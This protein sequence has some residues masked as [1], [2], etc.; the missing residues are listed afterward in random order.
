M[1]TP[2]EILIPPSDASPIDPG[3]IDA[4]ITDI[5]AELC[6]V[7]AALIEL[8][9]TQLAEIQADVAA[10]DKAVLDVADDE[11]ADVTWETLNALTTLENAA[12]ANLYETWIAAHY[13][14]ADVPIDAFPVPQSH[15][16]NPPLP[17]NPRPKGRRKKGIPEVPAP[18]PGN[19]AASPPVRRP[20]ALDTQAQ[21]DDDDDL[22]PPG[23]GSPGSSPP[24]G[25]FPPLPN[26]PTGSGASVGASS[27]V[28]PGSSLPG[29]ILLPG[30]GSS[31]AALPLSPASSG[32]AAGAPP[33]A[34]PATGPVATNGH[35]PGPNVQAPFPAG[36]LPVLTVNDADI[37]ALFSLTSADIWQGIGGLQGP[38]E[39]PADVETPQA[40]PPAPPVTTVDYLP[41]AAEL[42]PAQAGAPVVRRLPGLK[43]VNLDEQP[44]PF[45]RRGTE[46]TWCS[47][48]AII[49]PKAIALGNEILSG[50]KRNS[51]D[52]AIDR[53]HL[54]NFLYEFWKPEKVNRLG[55]AIFSFYGGLWGRNNSYLLKQWMTAAGELD[56][57]YH[58]DYLPLAAC[59]SYLQGIAEASFVV[60]RSV[61]G[62]WSLTATHTITQGV[63]GKPTMAGIGGGAS[64][65]AQDNEIFG[66]GLIKSGAGELRF[67]IAFLPVLQAL[68]YLINTVERG[69]T[70]TVGEALACFLAGEITQDEYL[71]YC[72]MKGLPDQQALS[73]AG[74]QRNRPNNQDVIAAARRR[75]INPQTMDAMLRENGVLADRDR[76]IFFQLSEQLPPVTDLIR[77][78]VRDVEDK[79]IIERFGLNDE[80]K[81]KWVGSL[82]GF[83][84]AQ[85]VSDELAR[86]YWRAHWRLPGLGQVYECLHR[87]RKGAVNAQGESI[88]TT[89]EDV[90]ALLGQDD[91]LPFWRDRLIAI[92][93]SPLTRVDAQRMYMTG[94]LDDKALQASFQDIGYAEENARNLVEF[95][96]YRR[97]DF[98]ESQRVCRD[99][100]KGGTT[101]DE[102]ERRLK[103]FKATDK[104]IEEVLRRLDMRIKAQVGKTCVASLRK[105]FL[106]GSFSDDE[107]RKE[108]LGRE[109]PQPQVEAYLGAWKCERAAAARTIPATTLCS[110]F[111]RNLITEADFRA[112]LIRLGY[113]GVDAARVVSQCKTQV[114]TPLKERSDRSEAKRAE[115]LA[116]L[117]ARAER[118]RKR[119]DAEGRRAERARDREGA[120][121]ARRKKKLRK[122]AEKLAGQTERTISEAAEELIGLI[123]M[124]IQSYALTQAEAEGLVI[125]A[126]RIWEVGGIDS[127]RDVVRELAQAEEEF[128]KDVNDST[129]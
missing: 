127:L 47:R 16:G 118:E 104:E 28:G 122:T 32:P 23:T 124:A 22:L 82:P 13:A 110:W 51:L 4:L 117:K 73:L 62:S 74:A 31:P 56:V 14:G 41:L 54:N 126:A 101:R 84:F 128:D 58:S 36:Q 61:N 64:Y 93:Y 97:E 89:L 121:E 7:C 60:N 98:L 33:G 111:A 105:Q 48:L 78:M 66:D 88:E 67:K 70:F 108:L 90:R 26:V 43:A 45:G 83:G 71:C 85:G 123:A 46:G 1:P 40:I 125:D 8:L 112:R 20:G 77:F 15:G 103:R 30:I 2:D 115:D 52:Y 37:E 69:D 129:P 107:A 114:V 12:D 44:M 6:A 87:L 116:R 38:G 3:R 5:E 109:L 11:L 100:V 76:E 18:S 120:A 9:D 72:A 35:V 68:E 94:V 65:A 55:T 27:P 79:R 106:Q 53:D 119:R 92:S 102:V 21:A 25:G 49:R 10:F 34:R 99:Y 17:E 24:A 19:G 42:V 96:K 113:S 50:Q 63:S 57:G 81:D 91:V 39:P 59:R 95:T 29:P 86:L 75:L 80:F